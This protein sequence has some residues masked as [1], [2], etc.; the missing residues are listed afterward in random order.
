MQNP[1]QADPRD[2]RQDGGVEQVDAGLPSR[3]SEEQPSAAETFDEEGA[4][5]AAKE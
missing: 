3:E 2:P 1:N 4:G 5:L